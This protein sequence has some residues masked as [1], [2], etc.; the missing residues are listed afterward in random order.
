MTIAAPVIAPATHAT[1]FHGLSDPCRL[2]ILQALCEGELTVTD[3]IARTKRSQSN[4]S[5][6]LACLLGCGLVTREQRGKYAVY[7]LADA[8][9]ATLLTL[10]DEVTR[11]VATGVDT[12]TLND[13]PSPS[14]EGRS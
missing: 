8:R 9:I 14:P 1:F 2:V 5:N 13:R 10:A 4:T 6:H 11:D 7:R 3:L 12:C